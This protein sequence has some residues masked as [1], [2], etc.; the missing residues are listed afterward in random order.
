MTAIPFGPLPLFEQSYANW[1][2]YPTNVITKSSY[3]TV[4]DRI[5][6][7]LDD[8][9]AILLTDPNIPSHIPKKTNEPAIKVPFRDLNETN[10]VKKNILDDDRLKIILGDESSVD[11]LLLVTRKDPKCRFM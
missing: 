2:R 6:S 1:Q 5:R 9:Q 4:L 8:S 3:P 7:R 11:P 10:F